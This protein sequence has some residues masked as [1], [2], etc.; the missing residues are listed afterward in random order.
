MDDTR[1]SKH[2]WAFLSHQLFGSDNAWITPPQKLFLWNAQGIYIDYY[3]PNPVIVHLVGGEYVLGKRITKVLPQPMA[4]GVRTSVFQTLD[5]Q[6]P[7]IEYYDLTMERQLYRVAVRFL[8]FQD[9]VLGLVNDFANIEEEK[10]S[11]GTPKRKHAPT[12]T[13]RKL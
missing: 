7:R 9:K 5:L 12:I 6:Q 10:V 2:A 4:K 13:Y 3:Y 11:V 1:L 8:P